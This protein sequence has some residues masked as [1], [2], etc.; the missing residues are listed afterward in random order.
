ME[1]NE[2]PHNRS[3]AQRSRSHVAEP[4]FFFTCSPGLRLRLQDLSFLWWHHHCPPARTEVLSVVTSSIDVCFRCRYDLGRFGICVEGTL[5][6]VGEKSEIE[7]GDK[8]QRNTAHSLGPIVCSGSVT[9]SLARTYDL[10]MAKL[11]CSR[12]QETSYHH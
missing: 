2:D 6:V 5:V 9:R 10:K 8:T 7:A 12:Y 1:L 11:T 3:C 4:S